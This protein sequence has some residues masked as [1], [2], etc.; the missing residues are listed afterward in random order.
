MHKQSYR[1]SMFLAALSAFGLYTSMYAFRKPFTAA[2]Y[3]ELG[4]AGIDYKTWLVMAQTV[5]YTLSKFVG[6]RIISAYNALSR[7]LSILLCIA[8]SWVSL[9]FF[10]IVPPPFELLF[11]FLNGLPLGMVYGFVFSYLE[12]RRFTEL[13]G[14]ILAASFILASGFTQSVGS[15]VLTYGKVNQWWM[16]FVTGSVFIIPVLFFTWLLH[17]TPDPTF[18]DKAL[19]TE[20]IPMGKKDRKLLFLSFWPG[21]T[22]LIVGYV[23]LTILRD[24]RSN[25]AA[26]IWKEAGEGSATVFTASEI[27]AS[28]IT[29]ILMSLL[30]CIRNNMAALLIQHGIIISGFI[31]SI[32]VTILY[33]YGWISS[34]WWMTGVGIGMYMGYVP[35]NS[36][37]FDRLIGAFK[38]ISNAGFLIYLA[39][40]F[41]YLGSNLVLIIKNFSDLKISWSSF[42]VDLIFIFSAVGILL[43]GLSAWYFK[44]KYYLRNSFQPRLKYA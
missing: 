34:F 22:V 41:G 17:K 31:I 18:T 1:W 16:P 11:I 19:R 2:Q 6:I 20:R 26:E 32:L 13:L 7:P 10:A 5:G 39:D 15:W 40:S 8:I 27:P 35:F 14:A 9:F 28:I 21:L 36:M 30:F 3:N 42:F 25:F 38:Y 43:T 33:E 4:Y 24:Y 23:L 12:G 37:L 44:N 29:L